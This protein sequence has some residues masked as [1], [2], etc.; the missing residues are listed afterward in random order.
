MIIKIELR[1]LT[2]FIIAIC[3]YCYGEVGNPDFE[4]SDPNGFPMEWEC[5]FYAK[6]QPVFSPQIESSYGST[7]NWKL[8]PEILHPFSNQKMLVLS[9][10]NLGRDVLSDRGVARIV[11]TFSAG[12]TFSFKYFFGTCDYFYPGVNSGSGWNDCARVRLIPTDPN[13][14]GL[15]E[16]KLLW[17][18]L[19]NDPN[20]N[21]NEQLDD[22]FELYQKVVAVGD[23]GS[24]EGW[25]PYAFTFDETNA[26]EYTVE[27]S[28]HDIYDKKTNSY[29]CI[30]NIICGNATDQGDLTLDMRVDLDDWAVFSQHYGDNCNDPNNN[31][32]YF[33]IFG[34]TQSIDYNED[35]TVYIDDAIPI[36]LNWL[37]QP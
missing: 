30:D 14:S 20:I 3:G 7:I 11:A 33:N 35:G 17:C 13:N 37:W 2:I 29:L 9:N 27:F 31:C 28:V 15:E 18:H 26:G 8:K 25:R 32:E 21:G 6:V 24:M 23:Y 10:G 5:E 19:A 1:L 12:E 22:N 34:Q 16:I 4:F 36:I